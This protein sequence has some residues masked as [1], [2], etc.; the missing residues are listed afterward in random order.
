MATHR[1]IANLKGPIGNTGPP[2]RIHVRNVVPVTDPN[3]TEVRI[4]G[5]SGNYTMDFYLPRGLSGADTVPTDEALAALIAT[6]GT[7][8]QTALEDLFRRTSDFGVQFDTD[9]APYIARGDDW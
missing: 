3:R 7:D 6:A 4:S 9:G 8:T 1:R 5:S 2:P